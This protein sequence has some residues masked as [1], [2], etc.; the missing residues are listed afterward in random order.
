MKR[1]EAFTETIYSQGG[2]SR[3]ADVVSP[4][5]GNDG[6]GVSQDSGNSAGG[7]ENTV[8]TARRQICIFVCGAVMNEGVYYLD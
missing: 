3:N 6:S 5:T 8:D 7:S 1:R 2:S 4:E